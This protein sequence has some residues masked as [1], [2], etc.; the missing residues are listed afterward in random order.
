[1]KV[2]AH[3]DFEGNINSLIVANAP[4]G[5][6]V[7]LSPQ[8]GLFVGEIEGVKIKDERDDEAIRKIAESHRIENPRS[9]LKLT[10]KR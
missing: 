9:L 6:E 10:K 5:M 3:Y 1:M 4:K 7:M 8:P 2:Y